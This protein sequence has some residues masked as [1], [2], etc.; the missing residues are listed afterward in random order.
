MTEGF[1]NVSRTV[2]HPQVIYV[3]LTFL[4][5]RYREGSVLEIGFSGCF[6]SCTEEL[7]T[8][9]PRPRYG[10]ETSLSHSHTSYLLVYPPL[11]Q[12]GWVCSSTRTGKVRSFRIWQRLS[13]SQT[14]GKSMSWWRREEEGWGQEDSTSRLGTGWHG[15]KET[16]V[17]IRGHVQTEK[18]DSSRLWVSPVRGIETSGPS[19]FL[20]NTN[21]PC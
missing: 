4:L 8:Q 20:R 9:G 2:Y 11:F 21:G 16:D 15:R 3:L 14:R 13:T 5:T 10:P 19:A 18:E 1:R 12:K 7:E 17:V 6:H